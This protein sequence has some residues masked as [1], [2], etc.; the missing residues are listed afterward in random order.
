MIILLT[1]K[2]INTMR[3]LK[4]F[5]AFSLAVFLFP[6][7]QTKATQPALKLWYDYPAINWMTSALPI[8]NGV[9]GGM[10]FGGVPQERM[11]FNDKTLWDGSTTVR[12]QYQ[13]FGNLYVN[14]PAHTTYTNYRRE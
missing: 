9:F 13:N 1:V 12:G 4:L 6:F 10:F 7:Q 3:F 5:Y 8:G 14:F 2:Y 11:Q